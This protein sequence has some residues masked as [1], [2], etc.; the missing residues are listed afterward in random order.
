MLRL[1]KPPFWTLLGVFLSNIVAFAAVGQTLPSNRSAASPAVSREIQNLEQEMEKLA[2]ET[3]L[4]IRQLKKIVAALQ[5]NQ[6]KQGSA[7]ASSETDIAE[8]TEAVRQWADRVVAVEAAVANGGSVSPDGSAFFTALDQGRLEDAAK[9]FAEFE[10]ASVR[11][12][13]QDQWKSITSQTSGDPSLGNDLAITML[14]Q[15]LGFY[16]EPENIAEARALYAKLV[17]Q[18]DE[19]ARLTK[20]R[21]PWLAGNKSIAIQTSGVT[22]TDVRFSPDGKLLAIAYLD[23]S[24]SLLDTGNWRRKI[25][26][27]AHSGAV[28]SLH[29]SSD[30]RYLLSAGA[31][32][33]AT[34]W[35]AANGKKLR[36]FVGHSETVNSARFSPDNRHVITASSDEKVILWD[37]DSGTQ[38]KTLVDET[39]CKRLERIEAGNLR[40]NDGCRFIVWMEPRFFADFSNDNS[41]VLVQSRTFA[42]QYEVPSGEFAGKP[43]AGTTY[44]HKTVGPHRY[45]FSDA[46]YFARGNSESLGGIFDGATN[47]PICSFPRQGGYGV[48]ALNADFAK[49][50][51]LIA[52]GIS[53]NQVLVYNSKDCAFI[54]QLEGFR[55]P[56]E[57]VSFASDGRFIAAAAGTRVIVWSDLSQPDASATPSATAVSIAR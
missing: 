13:Y 15:Y 56:I 48:N 21:T 37:A 55:M 5:S 45:A 25:R 51:S 12:Y 52:V 29:F 27:V 38:I 10:R 30:S 46:I 11:S 43:A 35:M 23:G 42:A 18:R 14:E 49:L 2:R 39:E 54:A 50:A 40:R 3:G 4:N 26:I 19:A 22:V 8:L 1:I 33:V 16:P 6:S 32:K 47:R 36:D 17:A 53:D 9:L 44:A 31:D 24:I 34:I 41:R 57:H 7:I 28:N 20:L